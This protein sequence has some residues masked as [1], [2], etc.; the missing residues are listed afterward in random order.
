MCYRLSASGLLPCPA[1]PLLRDRDV[2]KRRAESRLPACSSSACSS[3]YSR[4]ISFPTSRPCGSD[5]QLKRCPSDK[6]TGLRAL[7]RAGHLHPAASG[8]R[9]FLGKTACGFL[10]VPVHR[11]LLTATVNQV[12]HRHSALGVSSDVAWALSFALEQKLH[13][14]AKAAKVL[15]GC[16]DDCVM[17]LVLDAPSRPTGQ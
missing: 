13:L 15:A 4:R 12:V 16:E 9:P 14:A 8:H 7:A 6:R 17:I 3:R 11:L 1:C 2:L 10:G 5:R